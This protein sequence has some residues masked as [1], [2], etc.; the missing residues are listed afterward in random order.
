MVKL[1]PNELAQVDRFAKTHD[2]GI[3][4]SEMKHWGFQVGD[5]L[6]RYIKQADGSLKIENVSDVCP[7]PRK[8]RVVFVDELG[9]PWI[10]Q[11]SVRGGLGQTLYCMAQHNARLYRYKV[12]P[13]QV[14][15]SILGVQYNPRREYRMMR[16]NN[17]DYGGNV[18]TKQD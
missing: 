10:K 8:F 9:V 16:D 4:L 1:K 5:T 18:A 17:P 14:E 7:V 3:L 12:D 6:V 2:L 11:L 15:A 13:E